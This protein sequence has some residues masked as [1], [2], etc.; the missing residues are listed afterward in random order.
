[1]MALY[2]KAWIN[3]KSLSDNGS[4]DPTQDLRT[5]KY[6]EPKYAAMIDPADELPYVVVRPKVNRKKSDKKVMRMRNFW[7]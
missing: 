2:R 4:I 1:M 3:G 6:Q 5:S 7:D